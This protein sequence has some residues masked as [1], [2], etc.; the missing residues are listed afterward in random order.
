M[1][2]LTMIAMTW[3]SVFNLSWA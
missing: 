2:L 1:T 3:C